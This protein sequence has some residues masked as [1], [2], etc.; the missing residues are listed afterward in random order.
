MAFL[1]VRGTPAPP[2]AQVADGARP[3][4]GNAHGVA[5]GWWPNRTQ[6]QHLPAWPNLDQRRHGDTARTGR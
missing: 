4:S 5:S 1:I 6:Q 3:A 2:P